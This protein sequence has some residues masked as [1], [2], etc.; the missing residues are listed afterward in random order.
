[1]Y[2]FDPPHAQNEPGNVPQ[3]K[4]CRFR[5]DPKATE[6]YVEPE[7]LYDSNGE[8]PIIDSRYAQKPYKYC[9][10]VVAPPDE[11]NK[12]ARGPMATN[13][14]TIVMI[15]THKKTA[16]SWFAGPYAA[17]HEVAFTPRSPDG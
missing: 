9:F 16:T 5:I 15:D 6:M 13:N 17:L 4:Y 10:I 1:M 14:N 12:V 2:Y 3:T 11:G 8:F 7:A